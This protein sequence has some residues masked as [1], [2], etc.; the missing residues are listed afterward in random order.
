MQ[1]RWIYSFP[2]HFWTSFRLLSCANPSEVASGPLCKQ[3]LPL[4]WTINS[5]TNVIPELI[6]ELDYLS[7]LRNKCVPAP[8]FYKNTPPYNIRKYVAVCL[9]ACC[10]LCECCVSFLLTL[11]P[12]NNWHFYSINHKITDYRQTYKLLK[13]WA[14]PFKYILAHI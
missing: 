11:V 8:C 6:R 9:P 4:L 3:S 13:R 2:Q 7:F 1:M 10:M 12:K 14:C 5:H